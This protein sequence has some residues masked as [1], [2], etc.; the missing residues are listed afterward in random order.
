MEGRE[1]SPMTEYLTTRTG[2]SAPETPDTP[3]EAV[4]QDNTTPKQSLTSSNQF[5]ANPVIFRLRELR[6]LLGV[7]VQDAVPDELVARYYAL[8][9]G[10]NNKIVSW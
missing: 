8:C 1:G 2:R 3:W 10:N 5:V 4:G 6:M 9:Q 7:S